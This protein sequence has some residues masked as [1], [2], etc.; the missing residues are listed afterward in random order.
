MKHLEVEFKYS[1]DHQSLVEFHE[2]CSARN[3]RASITVSGEDYFYDNK[4]QSESFYRYRAGD[5]GVQLTFKK[6]TAKENNFIRIEHNIDLGWKAN[7]DDVEAYLSDLGYT[8][9]GKLFKIA[10]I[11]NYEDHNLVYYICFNQDMREIGRYIEI[12]MSEQYPWVNQ[13]QAW[14][15]LVA[16][17]KLCSK[18]GAGISKRINLSLYELFKDVK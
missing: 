17:E 6:K 18:I 9:A 14:D 13:S 8:Y 15:S 2:F 11:Y 3:P 12:E 7:K 16:L 5:D 4:H 1:A 10:F